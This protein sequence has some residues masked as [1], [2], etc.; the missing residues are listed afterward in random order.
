MKQRARKRIDVCAPRRVDERALD[1]LHDIVQH[2]IRNHRR[3]EA[4]E[5]RYF[6]VQRSV[7]RAVELAGLAR[8]PAGKKFS[9][10]WRLPACALDTAAS[11][12]MQAQEQIER[13]RGFEELIELVERKVKPVPYIG[14][15]YVYDTALRIGAKLRIEP[16]LVYLHAGTREG[17]RALGFDP[18]RRTIHPD[19]LPSEFKEPKPREIED[20]LCIYK[21]HLYR[22][23]QTKRTAR[24]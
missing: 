8:G 11:I 9:H 1:T 21:D 20:C 10:Q 3:R 24:G 7:S 2:Y 19:E 12:L 16:A 22:L 14:E 17:A 18:R 15:L 23:A 6:Q 4:R 13:C 5:L